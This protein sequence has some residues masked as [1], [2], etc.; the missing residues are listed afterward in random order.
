MIS[1]KKLVLVVG[2]DSLDS[3]TP[4]R[5]EAFKLLGYNV[6]FLDTKDHHYYKYDIKGIIRRISLRLNLPID[7]LNVNRKIKCIVKKH[8]FDLIWIEK[9]LDIYPSTIK[10]I[11]KNTKSIVINYNPDNAWAR[12]L[13]WRWYKLCFNLYDY[14]ASPRQETIDLAKKNFN[15]NIIKYEYSYCE[16]YHVID[17]KKNFIKFNKQFKSDISFFGSWEKDRCEYIN[18]IDEKYNLGIWGQSWSGKISSKLNRNEWL[19]ST[20]LPILVNSSQIN[21]C[22][23]NKS[24]NDLLTD[25]PFIITAAGGFL[26]SERTEVIKKYFIEGKE[27]EFFS[28]KEEMNDKINFYMNNNNLRS[29]IASAGKK[30]CFSNYTITN[31]LRNILNSIYA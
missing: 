12:S 13:G 10:L 27:A 28:S 15:I 19:R 8:S 20:D 1:K 24:N 16:K 9:G 26:L 22:F 4:C 6:I 14:H 21:L 2:Y 18:S 17:K 23:F 3:M 5:K 7:L 31:S 30:K 29:K 25:R 11:K